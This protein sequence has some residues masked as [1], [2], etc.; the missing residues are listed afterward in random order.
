MPENVS[1]DLIYEVL[2]ALQKDVAAIKAD[3]REMKSA[4]IGIREQ[5][6]TLDGNFLRQERVMASFDTRIDR[7]ETRLELTTSPVH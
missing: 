7:I 4:L 5:L 6:H 1:N 2:K 3:T